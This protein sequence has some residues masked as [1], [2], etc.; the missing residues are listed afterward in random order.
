MIHELLK[1]WHSGM[2]IESMKQIFKKCCSVCYFKHSASCGEF[3]FS[4]RKVNLLDC[5]WSLKCIF[6]ITFLQKG[7]SN[8]FCTCYIF[9]SWY[10]Q[11]LFSRYLLVD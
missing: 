5:G 3:C 7:F 8:L 9:F 6:H 11:N 4:L 1:A 2:N 10:G